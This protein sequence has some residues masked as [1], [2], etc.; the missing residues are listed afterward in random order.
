[1]THLPREKWKRGGTRLKLEVTR[2][3]GVL[4]NRLVVAGGENCQDHQVGELSRVLDNS[5]GG[6]C[7][8]GEG[9]A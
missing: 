5:E 3:I 2:L 1:M 6:Q 7:L 9:V 4:F 8:P